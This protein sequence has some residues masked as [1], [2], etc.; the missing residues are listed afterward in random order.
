MDKP[1]LVSKQPF[2]ASQRIRLL[3]ADCDPRECLKP[4][5]FRGARPDRGKESGE[6]NGDDRYWKVVDRHQV[7]ANIVPGTELHRM[8]FT[9]DAGIGK[10]TNLEWLLYALSQ[11]D[12]DRLAFLIKVSALPEPDQFLS[13]TLVNCLRLAEGN[14]PAAL[15]LDKA[16]RI[17]DRLRR[18]G[19][20]VLLFDALDQTRGDGRALA[21][22]KHLFEDA[23]W[24]RCRIIVSGR[25]YALQRHWEQLF[26]NGT[27]DWRFLRL[28]EFDEAQQRQYLGDEVYSRIPHEARPILSVPRVLHYLRRMS[29]ADLLKIRTPSDVFW[30]ST[31]KLLEEGLKAKDTEGLHPNEAR[32]LLSAIAF[33]MVASGANFDRIARPQMDEFQDDV[34]D[35][36]QR[37]RPRRAAYYTVHW[38]EAKLKQLAAMNEFLKH[39]LLEDGCPLEILWRDRSL[40]EFFAAYW[41]AHYCP[42][43]DARRLWEWIYLAED[44]KSNAYYWVW[45]YAAEMPA[46]ARNDEAWIRA[47]E[48]LYRPGDGTAQGTKRSCEMIWRSWETMK[49]APGGQAIIAQFEGAG[50]AVAAKMVF[51]RCPR[52]PR[53]DRKPFLM[54]SPEDEEGRYSDETLH[55]VVVTPF[56]MAQYP[57][58]NEQYEL[59]DPSHRQRRWEW[60]ERKDDDSKCPV[61]L[62]SWYDTWAFCR[63]LGKQYR[64]PT[65]AEWE[66]ACRAGT[67]TAF[68]FGN[69]LSSTQANFDGNYPYGGAPKGPDVERTTPVGSYKPNAFGLYDMHGNVW[70]WCADWYDAEYYRISPNVDPQ[71]PELSREGLRVLGGGSWVDN[72]VLCRAASRSRGA[73]GHRDFNIG[74]RVACSAPPRT[75]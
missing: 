31:G 3:V 32:L 60:S 7:A 59:F 51:R 30:Y 15:P 12:S 13:Q 17:L 42:P 22:L 70:E 44:P 43:E 38:G 21:T 9:T 66:Y 16:I 73:P 25:P 33:R 40:Q 75:Q 68:H 47:M 63:W 23:N 20:L 10:T 27:T 28:D 49:N 72:G 11:P 46:D 29:P 56:G 58:T 2:I 18:Q 37:A 41:L 64:L 26:G 61:V 36:C 67:R 55:R 39:G 57:V 74:F 4:E 34:V 62:V 5:Y 24:E 52:D 69:A 48:P 65:E 35:A 19:R 71:G 8:V 6:L 54:G 45:R 1:E 14:D 53:Q 50:H